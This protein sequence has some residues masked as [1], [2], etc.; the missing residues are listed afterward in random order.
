MLVEGVVAVVAG[1]VLGLLALGWAEVVPC[2][3][4]PWVVVVVG[5][6][7]VGHFGGLVV[8][9]LVRR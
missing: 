8:S 2:W 3:V 7:V 5:I 1:E 6:V 9:L 4:G